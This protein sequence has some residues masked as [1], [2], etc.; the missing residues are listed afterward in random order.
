MTRLASGMRTRLVPS[1]RCCTW[2]SG[3]VEKICVVFYP[4][5]SCLGHHLRVVKV[6]YVE[7]VCLTVLHMCSARL[8]NLSSLCSHPAFG[9]MFSASTRSR[10]FGGSQCHLIFPTF[11]V[12]CCSAQLECR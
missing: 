1:V 11:P 3:C 10:L 6:F 7:H 2:D 8:Q 12:P 9:D 5:G 4:Q